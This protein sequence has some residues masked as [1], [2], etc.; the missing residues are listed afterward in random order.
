MEGNTLV[1]K[2]SDPSKQEEHVVKMK[3]EGKN[4]VV[5]REDQ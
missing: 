1:E 5:V 4:L 3:M 2:F